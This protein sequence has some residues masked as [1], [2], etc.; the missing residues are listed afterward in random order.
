[1]WNKIWIGVKRLFTR[2]ARF[3][4]RCGYGVH[5]P[6]A[7]GLITDVIYEKDAYYAYGELKTKQKKEGWQQQ[8]WLKGNKRVNRLLFRLVNRTQP[9]KIILV[10]QPSD[11]VLYLQAAKPS[12]DFLYAVDLSGLFL[13]ADV[14]VDFLYLDDV[15]HPKMLEEAFNVCARRATPNSLF[16]VR[17]IGYTGPMKQLW[18]RLADDTRVGVTFDLFDVGLLFF[19]RS[20]IKQSYVVNF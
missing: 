17:G 15:S 18:R 4:H 8:S 9:G 10:G 7:F 3:R 19:D 2:V 14:P 6:F 1:M 11:A 13:D 20:K 5:S 16:V 12:A